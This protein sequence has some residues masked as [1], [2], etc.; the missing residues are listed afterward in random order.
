MLLYL[1][2]VQLAQA[3]LGFL[4][5]QPVQQALVDQGDPGDLGFLLVLVHPVVC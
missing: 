1:Q 3:A 4:Q 5:V 2:V